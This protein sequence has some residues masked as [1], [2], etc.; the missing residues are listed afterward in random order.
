MNSVDDQC[1]VEKSYMYINEN[2]SLLYIVVIDQFY[3][4]SMIKEVGVQLKSNSNRKDVS[5]VIILNHI[6]FPQIHY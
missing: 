6:L 4:Y 5:Q 2:G 1:E 3:R